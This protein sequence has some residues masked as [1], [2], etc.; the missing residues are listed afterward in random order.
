MKKIDISRY[1]SLMPG[2]IVY[3][4]PFGFLQRDG[5]NIVSGRTLERARL[6]RA[7]SEEREIKEDDRWTG[8]FETVASTIVYEKINEDGQKEQGY[9]Y[10]V[11]GCGF[12]KLY[13][14]TPPAKVGG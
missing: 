1:E 13:E 12:Y 11:I 2:T 5:K 10:T 8:K 7:C 9:H 4:E 14:P 6:I 3:V